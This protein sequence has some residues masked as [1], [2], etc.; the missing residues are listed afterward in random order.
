MNDTTITSTD[1]DVIINGKSYDVPDG[2]SISVDGRGV[3]VNGKPLL[4]IDESKPRPIFTVAIK[5]N[6]QIVKDV[7]SVTVEGDAGNVATTNGDVTIAKGVNGAVTS[8]NGNISAE[9][10]AGPVST[11]NGNVDPRFKK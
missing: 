4:P 9:T 11:V 6:V 5:G 3:F 2:A 1:G 10:I 8:V 7:R